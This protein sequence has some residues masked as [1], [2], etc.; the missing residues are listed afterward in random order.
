MKT[1]LTLL[2]IT[3][4]ALHAKVINLSNKQAKNWQIETR[5]A[6]LSNSLPIG[7]YMLE[8]STP[9]YFL[10]A[11]TLAFDAQVSQL[12][13]APYQ[14]IDQGA[15]V[16]D[17]SSPIWIEAQTDMLS[18]LISLKEI[19][20]KAYRKNRLC[21][22]G[23]IPK[24]E[25]TSINAMLSNANVK[26][27]ASKAVLKA[28]GADDETIQNIEKRLKITPTLSLHAPVTGTITTLNAQVGKTVS[29]STPLLIIQEAGR[30][31]LGA[32]IPQ[33]VIPTLKKHQNITIMIEGKSYP[34]T[35]INFSPIIN[36]QNQTRHVRFILD[37][38]VELLSGF[39]TQA[40]LSIPTKTRKIPK[41]SVVKSEGDTLLFIKTKKGYED[42]KVDILSEDDHFYYVADNPSLTHP[43]VTTSLA[44]LKALLGESD[45]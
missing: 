19:Q 4:L 30:K 27:S 38:D 5:Q 45:E 22:E 26:L 34:A 23:I 33:D 21:K 28:Y 31:W 36:R 7:N 14:S 2:I 3:Q 25:C 18:N 1:L 6:T 32:F 37:E 41:K 39:R 29:A 8:V 16:A 11:I 42:I 17:V 44:T 10:R 15:I 12:F 43:I 20:T 24:K 9:P 40:T 13:V 35:I